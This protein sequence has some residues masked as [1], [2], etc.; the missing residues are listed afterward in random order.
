[1]TRKISVRFT[2]SVVVA[3]VVVA[4]AIVPTW[5]SG[6]SRLWNSNHSAPKGAAN[7]PREPTFYDEADRYDLAAI[8][9][10]PSSYYRRSVPSR[11]W[12]IAPMPTGEKQHEELLIVG[13]RFRF[14]EANGRLPVPLTVRAKPGRPVTFT[15]LDQGR[16]ANGRL[17]I[18]IPADEDGYATI[19]FWV[20][21]MGDFRVL[22]GSPEN[23]GPAEFTLQALPAAELHD[24]ESGEYA[25]RYLAAKAKRVGK[26]EPLGKASSRK[27]PRTN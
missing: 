27:E 5:G 6:M 12:Q 20:S 25:K 11:V 10:D 8:R 13:Q 1:M 19:D 9:R 23:H 3:L 16:F 4:A 2:R 22:A 17:S 21:D 26:K 24:V 7:G 14:V 15:A 18:T